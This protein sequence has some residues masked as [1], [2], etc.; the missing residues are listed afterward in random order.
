MFMSFIIRIQI[1]QFCFAIF[2]SPL[3]SK[4]VETEQEFCCYVIIEYFTRRKRAT[5]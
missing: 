2:E 5:G 3:I 1:E 4:V